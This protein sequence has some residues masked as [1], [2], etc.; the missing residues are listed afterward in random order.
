[1]PVEGVGIV[2]DSQDE[3]QHKD[4]VKLFSE[5]WSRELHESYLNNLGLAKYLHSKT[6][7]LTKYMQVKR[8]KLFGEQVQRLVDIRKASSHKKDM[9]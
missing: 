3:E 7:D 2:R 6:T 5:S 1:M 9:R 4:L 8:K